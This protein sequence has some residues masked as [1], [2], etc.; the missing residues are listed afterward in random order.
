MFFLYLRTTTHI[1][2]NGQ[3][4]CCNYKESKYEN[5]KIFYNV[6]NTHKLK[7]KMYIHC[8]NLKQIKIEYLIFLIFILTTAQD[9]LP[10][11]R[12]RHALYI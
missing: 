10:P 5:P 9:I 2:K 4:K 12:F 8:S 3:Y 7:K 1:P 6:Y 11:T